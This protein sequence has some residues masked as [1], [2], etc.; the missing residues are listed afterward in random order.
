MLRKS[1]GKENRPHNFP[2]TDSK[3][4]LSYRTNSE[5]CFPATRCRRIHS[6]S[7]KHLSP[8]FRSR[9]LPDIAALFQKTADNERE[10]AKLWF[11]ALHEDKVPTTAVNLEDAAAGENYEWTDMYKGFAETAKEEGF[12]KIAF[13]M[14][15]APGPYSHPRN[16]CNPF[17]RSWPRR[18]T[19][20][21]LNTF[22]YYYTSSNVIRI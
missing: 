7:H 19:S 21:I 8:K 10:H 5:L 4:V 11:K 13:Q 2:Y 3:N 15:H 1:V 22:S 14:E 12:A 18:R 20:Y 6:S 9:T 17:P 16:R